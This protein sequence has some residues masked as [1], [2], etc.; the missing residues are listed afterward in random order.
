MKKEKVKKN[1]TEVKSVRISTELSKQLDLLCK[2]KKCTMNDLIKQC[3]MESF[4]DDLVFED[5]PALE[6]ILHHIKYFV[7]N[8]EH[9]GKPYPRITK[10]EE[11]ADD[12]DEFAG[13]PQLLIGDDT[14]IRQKNDKFYLFDF[15]DVDKEPFW[16]NQT[17]MIDFIEGKFDAY[18]IPM[19]VN[20]ITSYHYLKGYNKTLND[21]TEMHNDFIK[22][23]ES[24]NTHTLKKQLGFE[25]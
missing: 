19:E 25:E 16:M 3:V 6:Q 17:E 22:S 18:G 14:I 20:E 15:H 24:D 8:G 11:T 13:F 10:Y 12:D 1:E 9:E 21:L 7:P 23:Y 5:I 4:A 2:I